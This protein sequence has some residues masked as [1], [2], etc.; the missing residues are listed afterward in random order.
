MIALQRSIVSPTEGHHFTSLC[1]SNLLVSL[2]YIRGWVKTVADE[3][4]LS[5]C[6]NV[7]NTYI[8][9]RY[10]CRGMETCKV[11]TSWQV[12]LEVPTF[13]PS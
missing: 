1:I 7:L 2:T 4:V 12:I 13:D 8:S 9:R 11:T 10:I 5:I 6:H 3:N